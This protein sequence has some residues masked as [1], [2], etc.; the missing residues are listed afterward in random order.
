MENVPQAGADSLALAYL[1][2]VT[3][4]DP[5]LA[6]T[7]LQIA[8]FD[9][10]PA[11]W[12]T[13]RTRFETAANPGERRNFLAAMGSFRSPPLRQNSLDYALAGPLRP[14][15]VLA[16]PFAVGGSSEEGQEAQFQW[17]MKHYDA[18]MKR[19][20]PMFAVFMPFVGSGCSGDRLAA[21]QSFF[22]DPAHAPPGTEKELAKVTEAVEDC[23]KLRAREG[24][25]V[26][27]FLQRG[28]VAN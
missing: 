5:S 20:P 16:L 15:E 27:E 10:D 1:A 19:V 22:A 2:D 3:S 28:A 18:I 25:R 14:Q 8:A 17:A 12:E 13:Y 21:T 24:P 9:G 4:V 7:S 11:L 26:R 23:M 6:F